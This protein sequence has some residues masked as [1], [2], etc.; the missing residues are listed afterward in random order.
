MQSVEWLAGILE[1]EGHFCDTKSGSSGFYRTPVVT[2]YM[3]D[4]DVMEEVAK[5][6]YQ[7][8]GRSTKTIKRPLPSGK[9]AYGLFL[10]GLPAIKVMCAV[11]PFMC[12]R[13]SFSIRQVIAAWKPIKYR[14]AVEFKKA[15]GVA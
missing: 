14:D 11:L 1:G 8:G 4:N 15:L 5:M 7:I 13:R 10:T 2:I 6:F 9:T 12:A 3:T